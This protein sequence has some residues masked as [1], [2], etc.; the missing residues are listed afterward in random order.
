[1]DTIRRQIAAARRRL[2]MQRFGRIATW[3]LF[4]M[5]IV[6]AIGAAV[7][8]LRPLETPSDT[9]LALWAGGGIALALV[10]AAMITFLTRPTLAQAALEIDQRYGL[11]ERLSST[12]AMDDEDRETEMGRA[13]VEDAA[14]HAQRLVITERFAAGPSRRAWLPLIP[15]VFLVTLVFI[16]DA[17]HENIAGAGAQRV[18]KEEADQVRVAAEQLKKRLEQRRRQAEAEGLKEAEELFTKLERQADEIARRK[19]M[20]KKEALVALNDLKKQLQGRREQLG[21]PDQMRQSLAQM[22]DL[23][24]GP[25]ERVG[26]A[27]ENGDFGKAKEEVNQLAEKLR[28]GSLSEQ[29]KK[30]LAEQIEQLEKKVQEAAEEH[31]KAK[32]QLREQIAQARREGRMGEAAKLQ[33]QLDERERMDGQMRQLQQMAEGMKAAQQAMEKG[34]DQEA[35]E[36]L[37][38]IADQMGEMQ[39]QMDELQELQGAMEQLNNTK[40]QMAC[41][42]C[43]GAGCPAC[44]GMQ[45]DQP[46]TGG[47][48]AGWGRGQ[49]T[50]GGPQDEPEANAYESQVRGDA[51]AGRARVTG[52]T[53][54]ENRKGLTQQDVE[55]AVS[56]ALAE[57]SDP[58]DNQPLPRSQREHAR[59]YFDRLREGR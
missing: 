43:N 18:P 47:L 22:K 29:E 6:A 16:P 9:W 26:K 40:E 13:L 55:N 36:A 25:A 31:E 28:N 17:T 37:E 34:D 58:L 44:Q 2:L 56:D 39:A 5:L 8:K 3:S 57:E 27:L 42:Q 49:P 46:G 10:A 23:Q 51:K 33:Q 14:E 19:D 48:E 24:Q 59:Q 52:T 35:A 32:Q 15:A 7:P 1:M 21:S 50:A 53:G 4:A 54:G 12:W 45:G 38:A 30:Q 41:K 11:R 20:D